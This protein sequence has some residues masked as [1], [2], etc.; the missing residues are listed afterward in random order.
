MSSKMRKSGS[1]KSGTGRST[2]SDRGPVWRNATQEAAWKSLQKSDLSFLL[3]S[4][5]SGK[6]FI[7][8][9]YAIRGVL[10]GKYDKIVLTRPIVEA[11][12][13]LGYLPG[14]MA[15]KTDPY[16]IPLFD[17][18]D[19][20]AGRGT[21]ERTALGR[22]VVLAPL[23]FM[24]GR[25]LKNAVCLF[26]E[27]QN[28]TYTQLKLYLTRLGEG[29]KMIVTG[30]PSQ[31]DIRDSGLADVVERLGPVANVIR[32]KDSDVVRHPMVIEVLKRL[33]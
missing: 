2:P 11:G 27:A 16:M 33:P 17:A 22:A 1:K 10:D 29:S 13:K 9:A 25:T 5:G 31:C 20:L 6:T 24:R 21:A 15:A 28:A 3:G 8:M 32:F 7:A 23:S 14:S 18:M 4:A 26:D 12:E 30:D 19:D